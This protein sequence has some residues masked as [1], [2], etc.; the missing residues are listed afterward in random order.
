MSESYSSK[1]R[2]MSI[3]CAMLV[4]FI[5]VGSAFFGGPLHVGYKCTLK[6]QV[7]YLIT[8]G[9]EIE[10]AVKPYA[11]DRAQVSSQ[12]GEGLQASACAYAY[13]IKC[14][15]HGFLCAGGIVYVGQSVQLIQYYVYV[16]T[17]YSGGLDSDAFPFV[18]SG[19]GAELTVAHGALHAIQ[20]PG[21]QIHASGVTYQDDLVGQLFRL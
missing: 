7:T 21:N 10:Q 12:R 14:A 5:H 17:S 15:V 20:Q 13:Y 18:Q 6:L 11:L 1:I 3:V 2:N 9:I 8:S 16:V 4:A 19:C